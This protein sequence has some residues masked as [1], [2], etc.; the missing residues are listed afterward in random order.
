MPNKLKR[1]LPEDAPLGRNVIICK[2]R[3]PLPIQKRH[4]SLR[5]MQGGINRKGKNHQPN[6]NVYIFPESGDIQFLAALDD[7]PS[8]TRF[9][10]T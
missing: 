7:L 10:V 2:T 3:G 5:I 8:N 6:R 4:Y 9:V 1:Y